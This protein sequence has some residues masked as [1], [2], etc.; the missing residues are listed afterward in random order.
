MDFLAKC[1]IYHGDLAARNILLTDHL[2][3]KISDFGLSRRLYHE[4]GPCPVQKDMGKRLILPLKWMALEVLT[5]G[6]VVPMK[7]D[8]W[9]FG[10]VIWEMFELG[11]EPYRIGKHIVF[12]NQSVPLQNFGVNY[13]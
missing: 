7:S 13:T 11:A 9:S 5:T 3:A 6:Q 1:N 12:I 2:I 10:V 8:V 4:V